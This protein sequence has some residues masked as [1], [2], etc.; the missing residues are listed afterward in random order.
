MPHTQKGFQANSLHGIITDLW[1]DFPLLCH[2][3]KGFITVNVIPLYDDH[4][5][6]KHT[7]LT[8]EVARVTF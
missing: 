6:L 3:C 8:P 7:Y 4:S 2:L 1:S 5:Y